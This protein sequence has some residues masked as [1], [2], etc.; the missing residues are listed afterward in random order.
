MLDSKVF[1]ASKIIKHGDGL[2]IKLQGEE[3]KL[4]LEEFSFLNS[5]NIQNQMN[6]LRLGSRSKGYINQILMFKGDSIS[7]Q[8]HPR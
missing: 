8:L 5:P 1:L 3:F 7:L 6:N 2:Q 4:L